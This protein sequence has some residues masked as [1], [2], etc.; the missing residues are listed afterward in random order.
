MSAGKSGLPD[1]A[2]SAEE[3]D[4]DA[5]YPVRHGLGEDHDRDD[6]EEPGPGPEVRDE[7]V[8]RAAEEGPVRRRED[9]ER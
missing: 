5:E 8:F 6:D 3:L 2:G 4:H 7:R 1:Q 9:D